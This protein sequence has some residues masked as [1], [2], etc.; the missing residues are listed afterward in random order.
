MAQHYDFIVSGSGPARRRAAVVGEPGN[1][2][3]GLDVIGSIKMLNGNFCHV[4]RSLG[5]NFTIRT[6][7]DKRFLPGG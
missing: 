1:T 6:V 5:G 4:Y 7:Q 3:C 2:L